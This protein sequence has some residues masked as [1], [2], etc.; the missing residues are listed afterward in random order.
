M[1]FF[2]YITRKVFCD[3]SLEIICIYETCHQNLETIEH[4]R[5]VKETLLGALKK[6]HRNFGTD[7]IGLNILS[8]FERDGSQ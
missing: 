2:E 5:V 4:L 8:H 3:D 1:I 6:Q 7:V